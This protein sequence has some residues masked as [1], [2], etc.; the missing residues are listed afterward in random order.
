MSIERALCGRRASTVSLHAARRARWGMSTAAV[1]RRLASGGLR[2]V[3]PGVYAWPGA[4]AT[5]AQRV[6]AVCLCAGP[7]S[8]ASHATAAALLELDG[9]ARTSI[10][11]SGPRR[12][13]SPGVR[14]HRVRPLR[15]AEMDSS[16]P[17]PQPRRP[18][19]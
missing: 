3:H 11:A 2:V 4:P 5:W 10:E 8:A 17:F 1:D 13:T 18:V 7:H 6:M 15:S 19:L 14:A 9:F 16:M 12:I